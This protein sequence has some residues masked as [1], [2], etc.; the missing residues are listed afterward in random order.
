MHRT[1][2]K[3]SLRTSDRCHWCGNPFSFLAISSLKCIRG[4]GLPRQWCSAQR[5]CNSYDCQWQSYHD[6]CVH[7]LAMTYWTTQARKN[8]AC[9]KDG[10]ITTR[11]KARIARGGIPT[12]NNLSSGCIYPISFWGL[13]YAKPYCIQRKSMKSGTSF[14]QSASR[15]PPSI[16]HTCLHTTWRCSKRRMTS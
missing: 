5:I 4:C 15:W 11:A 9:P 16:W 8:R 12:N 1:T 14:S 2:T 10:K 3:L 6:S 7:W 13:L